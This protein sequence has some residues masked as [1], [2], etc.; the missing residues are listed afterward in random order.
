MNR[1]QTGLATGSTLP[2]N[3]KNGR[4][5]FL[6]VGLAVLLIVILAVA[7]GIYQHRTAEAQTA[8]GEAMQVYQTPVARPG[9]QIPPGIK[10]FPSEKE[11][12]SKANVLFVQTADD[13]GMTEPGKLAKYFAG[14]TYAEAGQKD[15]AETVLKQVG[16]SWNSD[17]AALA[18][19]A[20]AQ[21]Y[22]QAGRSGD[23]V[24]LY[25]QLAKGHA[26]TVPPAL[27]QL[28]LASLYS[29]QGKTEQARQIWAELK[30]HDK[31]ALGKP[32]IAAEVASQKLNPSPA[33]PGR[34]LR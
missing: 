8:F 26:T 9:Q 29:S 23:A 16:S 10:T 19:D 18:K 20:L 30:D 24:A 27:A 3:G 31:D 22:A 12:A 2:W 11:R 6:F 32:G 14:L 1:T 21:Q 17:V 28:Q 7:Y 15:Q 25:G 34:G 5:T 33:A 13:F 4:N